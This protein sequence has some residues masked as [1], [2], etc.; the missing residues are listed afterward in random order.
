MGRSVL[1][2]VLV[3]AVIAAASSAS[4]QAPV[5][6]PPLQVTEAKVRQN[7]DDLRF[8]LRFNRA[9]AATELTPAAGPAVCIVLSPGAS[10][11]RSVCVSRNG[12]HLVTTIGAVDATFNRSASS[13]VLRK[14]RAH[15]DGGFLQLRASARSLKVAL[16]R[17]LT[18][19]ALVG[20]QRF[21]A[22]SEL[23]FKT[24][25][26]SRP[27]FARLGRLRLLAT[28]DSMIQIIDSYL[29]QRLKRR[30]KTSVRSDAHISTGISSPSELNWVKKARNQAGSVKPD[31]TVMF[32]G[33]NDGFPIGG[34]PCCNAAWV[35]QYARRVAS[36]MRSYRRGGR[37]LVY[38]LTLPA[39][40][41]SRPNFAKV[42][43]RVNEAI[44]RAA[45][46][47]AS[48]VR[49]LDM[50]KVFTPGGVFRRTMSYGGRT[51]TVRQPDG[52]HL[53]TTGASIA[54]TVIVNRLR[55]DHVLPRL[56]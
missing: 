42:F 11:R 36:M 19:L 2:A 6:A 5:P 13:H 37:S 56:K 30:R 50:G 8:G 34:A 49:V 28:G 15:V 53:T 23:A 7:G 41:P 21:P 46:R 40:S 38:W 31:V 47:F 16:G 44:R 9:I 4:A 17:P 27:R 14:A 18:W 48:G 10:S 20:T 12:A 52:I 25:S 24:R 33:A 55:A 35:T 32:I 22:A 1:F 26:T 54:A 29:D 45:V 39:P 3:V 43:P 51:V